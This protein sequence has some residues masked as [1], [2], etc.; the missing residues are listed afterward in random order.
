MEPEVIWLDDLRRFGFLNV[1]NSTH[2]LV[3]YQTETGWTTEWVENDDY[4][5]WEERAIDFES[6]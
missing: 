6:E 2:S 5:L 4:D 1:R 3:T